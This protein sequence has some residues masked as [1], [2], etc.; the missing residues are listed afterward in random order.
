M[1][2]LV[3]PNFYDGS[4]IASRLMCELLKTDLID[5]LNKA[6]YTLDIV[7]VQPV[8]AE[9]L[10]E[11]RPNQHRISVYRKKIIASPGR[12]NFIHIADNGNVSLDLSSK[13]AI[14]MLESFSNG[15]LNFKIKLSNPQ[16]M[17]ETVHE[18]PYI[19]TKVISTMV[20]EPVARVYMLHKLLR[21]VSRQEEQ[22]VEEYYETLKKETLDLL[23]LE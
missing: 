8:T 3:K 7:G 22:S 9:D 6:G 13:L 2:G 14:D 17:V 20:V 11:N 21:D 15:N 19:R 10:L 12:C 1:M 23:E 16:D 5:L 4:T 18:T